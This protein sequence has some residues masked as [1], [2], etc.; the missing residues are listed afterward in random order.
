MNADSMAEMT[1]AAIS[2]RET[3][4]LRS[5]EKANEICSLFAAYRL[6]DVIGT[7]EPSSRNFTSPPSHRQMAIDLS[8]NEVRFLFFFFFFL[9][10]VE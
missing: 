7:L 5:R 8:T 1:V 4:I 3:S 2:R 10:K 6:M 9:K